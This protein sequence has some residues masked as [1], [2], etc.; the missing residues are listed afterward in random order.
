MYGILKFEN[1]D[2]VIGLG[3]CTEPRSEATFHPDILEI[4][5]KSVII[6]VPPLLPILSYVYAK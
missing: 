3:H 6:L 2:I 4:K 1:V 5:Y